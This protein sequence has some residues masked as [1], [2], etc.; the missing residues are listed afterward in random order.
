M[1][2]SS[3]LQSSDSSEEDSDIDHSDMS[4]AQVITTNR[5]Y[6]IVFLH[7]EVLAYETYDKSFKSM[8]SN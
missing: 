4:K 7:A 5:R 2:F 6:D 8:N 3:N 1:T